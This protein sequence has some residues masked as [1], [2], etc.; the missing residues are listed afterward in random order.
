MTLKTLTAQIGAGKMRERRRAH[1]HTAVLLTACL[2]FLSQAD[3]ADPPEITIRP[4]NLQ[5]RAN[6]IAAFY[7]AARGDPIPNIQWRKNGKRVSSK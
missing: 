6:G 5:V 4:R 7:C 2:F 3:A 1:H